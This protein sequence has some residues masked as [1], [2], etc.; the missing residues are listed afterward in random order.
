MPAAAQRSD[1]VFV[2]G[3]MQPGDAWAAVAERLAQRYSSTLLDH[4]QHSFEGRLD[5]IAAAG[6]W[7]SAPRCATPGATRGS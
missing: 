3:F 6:A 5:E 4:A 7:P 2:P 1:V